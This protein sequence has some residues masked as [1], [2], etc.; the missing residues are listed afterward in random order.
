M[1]RYGTETSVLVPTTILERLADELVEIRRVNDGR[2][3]TGDARIVKTIR[4]LRLLA[5]LE[6]MP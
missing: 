4:E 6:P 5:D 2:L 3:P 1:N